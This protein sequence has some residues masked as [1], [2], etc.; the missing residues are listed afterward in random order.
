M[1]HWDGLKPPQGNL[2]WSGGAY[3]STGTEDDWPTV[4]VTEEMADQ[5]ID[6]PRLHYWLLA[7]RRAS[8][9]CPAIVTPISRSHQSPPSILARELSHKDW[10][11]GV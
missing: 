4:E 8:N 7:A 3:L 6:E 5:L 2:H 1:E 9:K 10:K 11:F